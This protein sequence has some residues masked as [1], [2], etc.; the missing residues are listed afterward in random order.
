MTARGTTVAAAGVTI[1][2]RA[3]RIARLETRIAWRAG[4]AERFGPGEAL[5]GVPTSLASPAVER[6]CG[7]IPSV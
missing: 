4:L 7:S 1:A 3:G 6:R 2:V 5:A